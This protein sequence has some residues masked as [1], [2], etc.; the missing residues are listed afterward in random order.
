VTYLVAGDFLA[1]VLETYVVAISQFTKMMLCRFCSTAIPL[2]LL[3]AAG[4]VA[5]RLAS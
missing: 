2:H 3:T 1:F 5:R 4:E